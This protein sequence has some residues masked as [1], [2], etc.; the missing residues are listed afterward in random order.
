VNGWAHVA[1]AYLRGPWPGYAHVNYTDYNDLGE[2]T[3]TSFE[4]GAGLNAE[5]VNSSY[6]D[7]GALKSIVAPD[8]RVGVP[9]R[10]LALASYNAANQPIGLLSTNGTYALDRN[11]TWEQDTGRLS[12]LLGTNNRA[13]PNTANFLRLAYTYDKLGNPQ[14]IAGSV[15]AG[16][17]EPGYNAAW[18]YNYD[19]LNR[20]VYARTGTADPNQ[21]A[22]CGVD[23]NRAGV[24]G[25]NY[26]LSYS[27]T[28]D[29]LTG[30]TSTMGA[31]GQATYAYG[32]GEP[33]QTTAIAVSSGQ[34][35]GDPA[36]P[37]AG[38]LTYDSDG[39]IHTFARSSTDKTT[40][41]YDGL[42]NLT[43]SASSSVTGLDTTNA[44]SPDGIRVARQVKDP[45]SGT[46]TTVLYLGETQI[47]TTISTTAPPSTTWARNF[48]TP[49]GTPVATHTS[50]GWV[51]LMSDAQ[52]SVRFAR[53]AVDGV[54]HWYNYYPFG[55]P[56]PSSDAVA[57]AVSDP[58]A[59]FPAGHGYLD[60]TQDPD[61]T[62]RLDHRSY[63]AGLNIL[64]TPDP[65]LSP[66]DPQSYNPY[67]YSGNNPI[68]LSD[69]T[70]LSVKCDRTTG[71]CGDPGV[72][73]IPVTAHEEGVEYVDGDGNGDDSNPNSVT[74]DVTTLVTDIWQ[75]REYIE[76]HPIKTAIAVGEGTWDDAV[77]CFGHGSVG[78]CIST[79][80]LFADGAGAALKAI[81]YA[82]LAHKLAEIA[83]A[84]ETVSAT[85]KVGWSTGDDIY[86]LTKAGNKP[87]WSTVR[88]RFW[89]NEAASPKYGSW[90]DDQLA[91]M[92]TGRAP[93][94]YNPDKG[95]IE[96]MDLS[97]EPIPYRDGGT[98]VIPRWPQD[99]AAI[100]PY[101][102]PGY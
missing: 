40:Y 41:G 66:G 86:S 44:Y 46:T 36:L 24:T 25:A 63:D 47:T 13:D 52:G 79:V 8:D 87:A 100:D 85:A 55:D 14:R 10:T 4:A 49:H 71:G 22:E 60:K 38:D 29:R 20:L 6:S 90:S 51:W 2:V 78:A 88:A 97:H 102:Y 50:D 59:G 39:R 92:R 17:G 67:A 56:T 70:G 80:L 42:G 37:T 43:T 89:K 57:P 19:G 72:P 5:V 3:G 18:C 31:D 34:T 95:G 81:K 53:D 26:A 30:V 73:I 32:A 101:R 58:D 82:R 1:V 69:P 62:V 93:Q 98:L 99:H 33:H 54:N 48:T 45:V 76:H 96:S 28:Q 77:S 35:G 23:T 64:T 65:L 16:A 94:R 15:Q 11:F 83:E 12:T 27:Y 74:H 61:G 91:R 84:T 9:D 68:T 75:T 21:A 7:Y